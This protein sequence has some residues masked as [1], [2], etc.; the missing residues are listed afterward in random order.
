MRQE[1]KFRKIGIGAIFGGVMAALVAGILTVSLLMDEE[2]GWLTAGIFAVVT[3]VAVWA[4]WRS[5]RYWWN[6]DNLREYIL[7]DNEGIFA[8]I[9][10]SGKHYI[11]YDWLVYMRLDYSTNEGRAYGGKLYLEYRR[12]DQSE[13]DEP[14]QCVLDLERLKPLPVPWLVRVLGMADGYLTELKVLH[15]A[16]RERCRPGQLAG[17]SVIQTMRD[18]AWLEAEKQ[19]T[20]EWLASW[21]GKPY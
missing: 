5:C 9:Y 13:T 10:P 12:P 16:I 4:T 19:R 20:R 3:L 2:A 7:L 1:W 14:Q 15:Q 18:K 21:K 6:T 8:Q 17:Y 11:L